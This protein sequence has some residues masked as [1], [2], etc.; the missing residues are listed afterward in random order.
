MKKFPRAIFILFTVSLAFLASCEDPEN[1]N[2]DENIRAK[3]TGSWSCAEAG[4]MTYPVNI[5]EDPSNSAQVLIGNFHYFGT[6]YKAYA[7]VTTNN[8]TIPSQ[9]LCGNTINGDGTLTGTS[10][11]EL[12]YYVNDHTDIKTVNAVY[13]K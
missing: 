8:I 4:G 2:E 7:V 11:I 1:N 12:K 13:S 3:Y 10:R 6:S 9:E 5:T